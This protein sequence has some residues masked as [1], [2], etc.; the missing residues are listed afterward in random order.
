MRN[1]L[2]IALPK[3]KLYG[4]AVDI[5]AEAGLCV[6][7]L[8]EDSRKMVF[9]NEKAGLKYI[10]C[11]PTDIPTFVEYGAA[12]LGI[13]GK[14]TIVEQ[15]KDLMELVDLRFGYCRFVVALPEVTAH[16]RDISQFNHRRVATKFPNVAENYFRQ[17][18]MQVEV[19]KLHGNI[20]LAP[21]V[22]LAD[23]IVDIV[24]TGRTLRENQLVAIEDIFSAT[25]RMVA[26]RVSYRLKHS[27][28][29]PLIEEVRRNVKD[30]EVRS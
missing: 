8:K 16:G 15:D 10:I 1:L 2:T 7:G 22:G 5:L 3:G 18:G 12:D 11:R 24:S 9:T 25:A 4:D 23:M 14:D 20:E 26:N 29:Q 30:K 28:I 21:A 27:R 17:R 19:I 6:D 13:V